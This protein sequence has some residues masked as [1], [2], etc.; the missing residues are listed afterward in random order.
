VDSPAAAAKAPNGEGF[1]PG[2]R[3]VGMTDPE[4]PD[5]VT[6]LKDVFEYHRRMAKLAGRPVTL[7]VQRA[8]Q[9][10]DADPT[11]ITVP[12]AY[13]KSTGLRMRMGEVVA[14]RQGSPA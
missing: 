1:R 4:T 11:P 8:D 10:A 6:P 3:I 2:D 7:H 9:P 14:T 5:K 13:R 12:P